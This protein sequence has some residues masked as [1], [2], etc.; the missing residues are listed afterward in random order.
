MPGRFKAIRCGRRWGK[1]ALAA[2]IICDRAARGESWGLFAPDYKI[3]SETYREIYEILDPVTES[4]SK[5][6]GVIRLLGGG[7]VDFWTLNNPR[8]GRSRKYHGVMID[9]A[10][11]AGPDMQMI[12]E[13]SIK[14]A[15]LDHMGVGWALSTPAGKD[16]GNW[17]YNI[18][19]DPAHGFVEFHAPTSSNPYLPQ[20]E[21]ARLERDNSPEVYRQ[22][23]LGEFV[24][25]SGV[26]FFTMDALL[27]DGAP[28]PMPDRCDTVFATMDTAI[29]SGLEHDATGAVFWAYNSLAN[30]CLHILDWDILQ[31]EGAALEGWLP[32]VFARLEELSRE[33]GARRG[34]IGVMIEDKAS[35]TVLLQ[36]ARNSGWPAYPI[37]SK[38]TSMGKNERAI[39]A[40]P[41]VYRGDIKITDTAFHKTKVHK[42][43]SANHLIA[44]ITSFRIGSQDGASDDLLDCLCYGIAMGR[45]T[46]AGTRRGI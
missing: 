7:R 11:F 18:C 2:T 33:C 44:Q 32:S 45:G 28:V 38:L 34:S 6:D 31:I 20:D 17:F 46:N 25:W 16:E 19:T 3:T 22:E 23:Y 14:P 29:K 30:P 12:W 37:E 8:A 1:T 27:V 10:A 5:I 9:E 35:G 4:A 21:L 36:Q 43:R 41:Y 39:A 24:D 42:G 26:A 40:S 13:R 15:L